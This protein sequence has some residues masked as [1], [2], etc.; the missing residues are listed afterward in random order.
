MRELAESSEGISPFDDAFDATM[1]VFEMMKH[2]PRAILGAQ[3]GG[4]ESKAL[5]PEWFPGSLGPEEEKVEPERLRDLEDEFED[6]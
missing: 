6:D 3:G 4:E 5:L 1:A 2:L